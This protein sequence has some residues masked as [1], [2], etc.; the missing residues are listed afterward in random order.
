MAFEEHDSAITYDETHNSG[1]RT[2]SRRT[3]RAASFFSIF[4]SLV[5]IG[6]FIYGMYAGFGGQLGYTAA[7][8]ANTTGNPTIPF[9][10]RSKTIHF[11]ALGDS[12]THGL[13]DASGQGYAGDVSAKYRSTGYDVVETNLGIDGLTSPGLLHEL[14]QPSVQ[15]AIHT[16]NVI[17]ISI[18]ANDLSHAAGL[19]NINQK[20]IQSAQTQFNSHLTTIL[21]TIR[22]LNPSAPTVLIGLYNPYAAFPSVARKTD[23]VIENWDVAEDSLVSSFP[24]TVVVQTFDLFHTNQA[25]YLYID[26]YH[27][28]QQGY[29]RIAD[30]VWQ[31]LQA[32]EA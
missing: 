27:P 18:G 9:G 28:N 15:N 26:H 8:T 3:V 5:L 31:D 2:L 11:V 12:L 6:G 10:N 7:P 29:S 21:K 16:A 25:K 19:P 23:E 24:R 4:A 30:R 1:R 17:L 22:Q 13:G 14:N 20:K 32:F